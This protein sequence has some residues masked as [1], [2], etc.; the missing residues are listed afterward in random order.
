MLNLNNIAIVGVGLKFPGGSID[1]HTYW[2]N[3]ISGVDAIIEVKNERWNSDLHYFKGK[4]K[5]RSKSKTK[6]GGFVDDITGFDAAFFGISPREAD[7]LDPQQRMLLEVCWNA[8]EDAGLIQS[9]V[10][11]VQTSVYIGGF[12]LDYMVQQLNGVDLNSIEPH[13]ATGI[14]MTLLANRLSYVFGLQ[15]PSLSIDTACSSSL[16]ATHMACTSLLSGESDIALAGGV[17]ALLIPSFFVAE[18]QAGMLSPTGRSRTFDSRADGYVRGEGAGIV[19]LKRLQDAID[20]GDRIYATIEASGVNHDGNSE[21]LTVPNGQAQMKLMREVYKK[22]GVNPSE[23]TFI[24]AHGTGTP[25]GDPIEA[26]AVG[27]VVGRNRSNNN[28]CYISSVKTNIGHTEAAAGVAGLIKA[29]LCVYHRSLPPHLHFQKVNKGIDL[30]ALSL[31]IP[32]SVTP[33]E[34]PAIEILA[35]VNSFGFGGTNA[36]VLLRGFS[37]QDI[38]LSNNVTRL[39]PNQAHEIYPK[40]IPISARC[41]ESLS[42]IALRLSDTIDTMTKDSELADLVHSLCVRRDHHDIRA[43]IKG[44]TTSNIVTKLREFVTDSHNSDIVTSSEEHIMSIDSDQKKMAWVYT[45]MGPQWWGMGQSLYQDEATFRV[46]I[47]KVC[48][49]FDQYCIKDG[50]SLKEEMFKSEDTSNIHR[51]DIAQWANFAIQY[52]LS[53]TWEHWG[54][55]PDYVVG[56]SAGE[57]M[58]AYQSGALNFE[59]AV[60]VTYHRSRLQQLTTGE[61]KMIAVDVSEGEAQKLI[62]SVSSDELSVAAI[63]AETSL[64]IAGSEKAIDALEVHLQSH[65]VF[66]KVLRVNIPYHSHVMEKLE[67][68]LIDALSTIK[69]QKTHIPLYSTVT[70][71]LID[72]EQLDAVYWYKNIRQPVYFYHAVQNLLKQSVKNF[73]EIGPH[74]VL[75]NAIKASLHDSGVKE[76]G[77]R[78]FYSLNRK[79]A[80]QDALLNSLSKI[81]CAGYNPCWSAINELSEN[82]SFTPFPHY[83]WIHKHYWHEPPCAQKARISRNAHPLLAHRHDSINPIWDVDIFSNDIA[84]LSQHQIQGSNVFPGSA[85]IEMFL[86]ASKEVYGQDLSFE[87]SN[88]S[89]KKAIYLKTDEKIIIQLSLNIQEGTFTVASR[90]YGYEKQAWD[91]NATATL[92]MCHAPNNDALLIENISERC[93][94]VFS[95]LQ[96]YKAFEKFGLQYGPL[97]QGIHSLQQGDGEALM[98][99]SLKEEISQQLY[100]YCVHPVMGDLCLQAIAA[101]MPITSKNPENVFLPVS[102][103]KIRLLGSV[104]HAVYIHSKI[105]HQDALGLSCDISLLDKEGNIL[106]QFEQARAKAV[107]ASDGKRIKTQQAYQIQWKSEGTTQHS[108]SLNNNAHIESMPGTWIIFSNGDSAQKKIQKQLQEHGDHTLC[109]FQNDRYEKLEDS[110]LIDPNNKKHFTKIMESI[111]ASTPHIKGVIYLWACQNIAFNHEQHQEHIDEQRTEYT[112]ANDNALKLVTI[113]P[114][115]LI[116]TIVAQK[117]Q[118]NIAPKIWMVTDRA[119]AVA[120]EIVNPLQSALWGLGR[121]AGQVEHKTNW[122]ALIDLNYCKDSDIDLLIHEIRHDSNEDQVAYREGSRYVPRL[123]HITDLHHEY[124]PIFRSDASY[125]ITGGLGALGLVT[126]K[127]LVKNGAKHLVLLGRSPLPERLLWPSIMENNESNKSNHFHKIQTIIELENLGCH[128]TTASVD[129]ANYNDL[130]SFVSTYEAQTTPPILAVY[131]TAGVAIPSLIVDLDEDNFSQVLSGKIQGAL[132]L[133][134]LFESRQLDAFV[135]YSSLASVVTSS[136]Q[137]SYSAANAFLDSFAHW[138]R[139]QGLAALSINWGPWMESGLAAEL[140]LVDFFASRGFFAMTNLQGVNMLSALTLTQHAQAVIVSAEWRT[141]VQVGYPEG[142]APAHLEDVLQHELDNM[143]EYSQGGDELGENFLFSYIEIEEDDLKKEF[144]V[145]VI[146]EEAVRLLR[147]DATD[148]TGEHSFTAMGL[149]SMLAMDLRNR[150]EV[151]LGTSLAVVDLLNNQPI[152]ELAIK[153]FEQ[154]ESQ[155]KALNDEY[156]V[157]L[158]DIESKSQKQVESMK[159]AI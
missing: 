53:K 125:L 130:K 21:N 124:P 38:D 131:H 68:Q 149:D 159:G 56:H 47:D 32:T 36:H 142:I 25:V 82:A 34:K 135:L 140:N 139:N 87:I 108:D 65:D 126:A 90:P 7:T 91:I 76:P 49:E 158:A 69:P 133:H 101:T 12:T 106:L 26:N 14:M 105:T 122:G 116:Q 114:T 11:N 27:N 143:E 62:D 132:N 64:T 111:A 42:Q 146:I 151:L 79:Q 147:I 3:L 83:P 152:G 10:T 99:L 144:I 23:L 63:N 46:A 138:R 52:A 43:V 74:P 118:D 2:K 154:L 157:D 54:L 119:Q 141:A 97:F 67:T 94:Q 40:L 8:F 35:G 104:K 73:L 127:W 103:D 48:E 88:L 13:T 123:A 30:D 115:Y 145:T 156:E 45:G 98:T 29:A 28:P 134:R 39:T 109:I 4:E 102:V 61:G 72:G 31:K 41:N 150:I 66:S 93:T 86:Q 148:I 18:S 17:N 112:Q 155:I 20:N 100:Q 84:Y 57:P 9:A 117:W 37:Q 92:H 22:A 96:I 121:V 85:Y 153:L 81:Y 136:G 24:E 71:E 6:W 58:A 95:D 50:W 107:G 15:G 60:L 5:R 1:A 120:G 110:Y 128:I 70:G 77:T 33:I 129:I 75:A 89:L 59:D 44:D 78:L 51:S 55:A 80:E 137:A 19:V 113:T 16:V